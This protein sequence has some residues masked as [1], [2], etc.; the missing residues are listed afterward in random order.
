[1]ARSNRVWFRVRADRA[2]VVSHAR[3]GLLWATAAFSGLVTR[4]SAALIDGPG[5]WAGRGESQRPYDPCLG[6]AVPNEVEKALWPEP[7]TD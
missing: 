4:V 6:S 7:F 2:G 3:A 5:A 1:M